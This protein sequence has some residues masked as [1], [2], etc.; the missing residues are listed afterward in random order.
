VSHLGLA[1]S[2]SLVAV[3]ALVLSGCGSKPNGPD[4]A[5]QGPVVVDGVVNL[6]ALQQLVDTER[7]RSQQ[8][9]E[10]ELVRLGNVL[11]RELWKES[12]LESAL[13]GTRAVDVVFAAH[14]QA[15]TVIR[16]GRSATSRS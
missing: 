12:G 2:L 5:K 13:G 3:A 10:R 8:Q 9:Q 1:R 7:V 11:E 4:H 15:I 16:R 6:S 14:C